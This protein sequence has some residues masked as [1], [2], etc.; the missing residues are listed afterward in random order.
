M[1][2]KKRNIEKKCNKMQKEKGRNKLVKC[3]SYY[4]KEKHFEEIE[5]EEVSLKMKTRIYEKESIIDKQ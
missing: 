2:S 5:C 1:Q 3:T 4:V